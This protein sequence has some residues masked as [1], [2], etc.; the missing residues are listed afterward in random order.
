[1]RRT[2]PL[3]NVVDVSA[4]VLIKS[5]YLLLLVF[6]L[7]LTF[8]ASYY[9]NTK[10]CK[11][12]ERVARRLYWAFI[13]V[14]F[15]G[16]SIGFLAFTISRSNVSYFLTSITLIFDISIPILFI[17]FGGV[18]R[19]LTTRST[20]SFPVLIQKH[21]KRVSIISIILGCYLLLLPMVRISV[22][23]LKNFVYASSGYN[24]ISSIIEVTVSILFFFIPSVVTFGIII[25][26]TSISFLHNAITDRNA[27]AGAFKM[28]WKEFEKNTDGAHD[29]TSPSMFYHDHSVFDGD[30]K[31]HIQLQS[32]DTSVYR[33]VSLGNTPPNPYTSY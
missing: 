20:V 29:E 33:D 4:S 1:M 32:G 28:K 26:P 18:L 10:M 30:T 16:A 19:R 9:Y 24:A 21:L 11:Q 17:I 15:F 12:F 6:W 25:A 22:L 5:T 27:K 7:E 31:D 23:I 2:C 8:N 14:Y 13:G 3:I